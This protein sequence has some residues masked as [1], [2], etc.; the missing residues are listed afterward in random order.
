MIGMLEH[1]VRDAKSL[2]DARRRHAWRIPSDY[3]V[4]VDCLDRNAHQSERV[5]L[6]YADDEGHEER[7]TFGQLIRASHKM[8]NALRGLGVRRGDVVA[9][10]TPQRP[11]T[12]I[13]HMGLYRIGAI[14]LPISK[15][16][17][18]DAIR[19]RLQNSGAVA[20]LMEPETVHKLEG[21]RDE[22]PTLRHVIVAGGRGDGLSFDALLEAAS[23]APVH[24][25]SSA[26]DPILLMYTSGTTGNPK[27]VLHAARYVPGHNGIDYSYN[28]LRD[29]DLYYSPADWAWAGGLLDGLLGIWPYGIPVLAYRSR[30]RFDPDVTLHLLSKYGATVGLY[31][32]TALKSLREVERPRD[33]H[34]K[35]RLRCVVSGAE[36]VSPELG[37]WVDEV[38]R[39]EF[40]QGFGQT[41]AN[42]F[43]GTCSALE[44]F[45]LEALGKAYPGHDVA[46]VDAEGHVVPHGQVGEIAIRRDS[47][48]VMKEYWKN[49]DAM[50]EKF[51]GE[52]CLTG[53]LGHADDEG[54]LYFQGRAD[55]VI[56]T[57]GYR[58]GPAEVEAS[59]MEVPGVA[60]CAVIGVSDPQRGQAIKA[61]V[62]VL[63]GHAPDDALIRRIQA[64]VKRKLA[65]HEYPRE[66]EFRD[67]F[68]MT[69]TGKVRRRDLREEE[70]RK[71]KP[72]S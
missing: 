43:I 66:I 63:P 42:Y 16:F 28:F 29:G 40:N 51:A 46:V 25:P 37:R 67:E 68:P 50:R 26:E 23:D 13:L 38:L 6:Y 8:A 3:N 1:T 10:H 53:D 18:P 49:P 4:A 56:K 65:A 69:V 57:S 2:A 27:G 21:I 15:L 54:Y 44:P 11:E 55:D 19:Y 20:I 32:P 52:W 5:A 17:G 14:G 41:E 64:H 33:E 30:A 36:P 12:A 48:V 22:V 61:F 24:E 9:V 7:Y 72:A 59:I 47:P 31:P 45:K 35:L 58:V 39:V 62:K 60:S 34:P 71:R 70:E